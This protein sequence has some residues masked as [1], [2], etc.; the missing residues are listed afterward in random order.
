MT[1]AADG[2]AALA[3]LGIANQS[4]VQ[5]KLLDADES[6]SPRSAHLID[7]DG[8]KSRLLSGQHVHLMQT[9]AGNGCTAPV[10]ATTTGLSEDKL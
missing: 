7:E 5:W 1:A 4:G 6:D 3:C 8:A 10:F 9:M 2:T